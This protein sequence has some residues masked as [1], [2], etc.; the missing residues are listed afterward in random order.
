MV[1]DVVLVVNGF[2]FDMFFLEM[3]STLSLSF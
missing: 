2:E 3:V 1:F